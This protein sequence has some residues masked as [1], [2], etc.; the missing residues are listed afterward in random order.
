MKDAIVKFLKQLNYLELSEAKKKKT[1][2]KTLQIN[3]ISFCK[4]VHFGL[5]PNSNMLNNKKFCTTKGVDAKN[6]FDPDG[7][8]MH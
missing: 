8:R 2:L 4:V 1:V 5:K 7:S 3:S 6:G